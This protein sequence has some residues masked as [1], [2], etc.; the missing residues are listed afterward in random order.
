[1]KGGEK[2]QEFF[3]N[4][5]FS[6]Y[7]WQILTPLIFSSADIVTGFLQALIN[8]NVESKIMRIGLYHKLLLVIV[9]LL[10]V[11]LN[12]AFSINW[13]I[14]TVSIYI[15]IMELT[16]I[17]ENLKKAGLDIKI[18]DYVAEKKKGE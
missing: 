17:L 3:Q 14:P 6:N 5:E 15:I 12:Y 18:L 13:I 11:V 9:L 2:L 7:I 8:N 4:L 16:S 10:A 1:M